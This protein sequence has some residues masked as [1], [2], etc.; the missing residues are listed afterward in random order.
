MEKGRKKGLA[1]EA[2]PEEGKGPCIILRK[3]EVLRK[4]NAP[5]DNEKHLKKADK[6]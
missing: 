4:G 5:K 3:G 6:Q 1:E 2:P